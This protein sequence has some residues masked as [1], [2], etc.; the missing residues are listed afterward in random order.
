M[1]LTLL[2]EGTFTVATNNALAR[3]LADAIPSLGFREPT[4]KPA[5]SPE[6]D[7]TIYI[8]AGQN[9]LIQKSQVIKVTVRSDEMIDIL[10]PSG[11]PEQ[12]ADLIGSEGFYVVGSLGEAVA[13]LRY[14]MD[15]LKG[16]SS[17]N[18]TAGN[19]NE[20]AKID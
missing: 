19:I 6:D 18:L 13:R 10:I 4:L 1:R 11:H 8:E 7:A 9:E 2:T 16:I 14:V 5:D 17:G 12:L 3:K 15:K 20:F